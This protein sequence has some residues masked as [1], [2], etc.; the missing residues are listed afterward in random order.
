MIKYLLLLTFST[1]LLAKNINCDFINKN[2]EYICK[3]VTKKG[4]SVKYV[5]SFLF[6]DKASKINE[7]SFK[8]FSYKKT[9]SHRK[10]EKKANNSLV[11]KIPKIIAHV[12]KYSDVY[13]EAEKRFGVNREIVASILMKETRLGKAHLSF[14]AFIVFN[15]LIKKVKIRTSRDK[16]LLNM[17]KNNIVSIIKHCFDNK[18][19]PK[20]CNLPSSYAGAVGIPQFMPASFVFAVPYKKNGVDL[21]RMQDAIMSASNFLNKNAGFKK[22]IEWNKMPNLAKVEQDWYDYSFIHKDSSLVYSKSK[23]KKIKFNCFS[24]N[25][26]ELQYLR[27]YAKKIMRYNN[28]SNYVIGVMRLAYDTHQG[29]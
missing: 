7:Q 25:K 14:D 29:L 15:T 17:S 24:C 13:D 21:T 12:K 28:S 6:S 19:E 5:N 22:L 20:N 23:R 26:P 1:L 2:Y 3:K 18:I 9:L 8:L 16:R 10:D 11:E 4:V 27:G